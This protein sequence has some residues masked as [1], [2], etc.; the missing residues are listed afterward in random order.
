ACALC[1]PTIWVGGALYAVWIMQRWI[2]LG[3]AP[4]RFALSFAIAGLCIVVVMLPWTLRNW[5]IVG[6]PLFTTTH[7]GYTLLL[8]N[9]HAFYQQVAA[10][11]LLDEWRNPAP[12]RFQQAW[13]ADLIVQME[14]ELGPCATEV[15]RDRWMYRQALETIAFEPRMF[16]RACAL[17]FLEFW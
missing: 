10:K 15:E 17:R 8:G 7:G 12:D 1:R 4:R 11:P 9:N 16:L 5:R 6:A 13:F 3:I 14:R 2:R